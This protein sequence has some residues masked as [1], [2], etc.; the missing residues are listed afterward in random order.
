VSSISGVVQLGYQYDDVGNIMQISDTRPNR[1]QDFTYDELDRIK[2]AVSGLASITYNYDAHG[3]QQASNYTY[4]SGNPFRLQTVNGGSIGYDSNGNLT[5]ALGRTYTFGTRNL[6]DT[7]L[8]GSTTTRFVYDADDWRLKKSVDGGGPAFYYVR[9]P[10][11]QLLM[12]WQHTTTTDQMR[13]YIYLGSRLIAAVRANGRPAG[14]AADPSPP[15]T[16]RLLAGQS[17][18]SEQTLVSA[19]GRYRLRYR[20]DGNLVLNDLQ[21]GEAQLWESG[22]QFTRAGQAAMQGDGNFAI[23]NPELLACWSTGTQGNDGAYLLL[24]GDGN[25][26][27]YSAAGVA[28]WDR[29]VPTPSQYSCPI[30]PPTGSGVLTTDEQLAPGQQ[31][32]SDNGRYRLEYQNDGN[33]V[34][35]DLQTST[36]LWASDTDGTVP[37]RVLMQSDGNLVIYDAADAACWAS[38]TV[39]Y[40]GAY[41]T[42]QSDGN[43]VIYSQ[44][45][46]PVWDRSVYVPPTGSCL[47][48]PPPPASDT[49][50]PGES[51]FPGDEVRS[52]NLRYQLAYQGD[53]NLVLYDTQTSTALWSSGTNGTSPF[54]TAMQ[55]DG[56][57]VVYDI[58]GIPRWSSDTAGWYNAYLA[59]KNDGNL[60]IYSAGGV[61]IW[62]R[63]TP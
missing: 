11:G 7:A 19:N 26:V 48:A 57:L 28:L 62:Y 43:L 40:Q 47:P 25:L 5:S 14:V 46:V 55:G 52:Q 22:T 49:L 36:E 4:T 51:L 17:L 27:V 60:V 53:G 16:D 2:T 13:D 3:N 23:Y 24:Q 42:V 39:G 59:V 63:F 9:G 35:T 45:G 50:T 30:T 12:E 56:N 41:L 32:V 10:G 1:T 44:F 34:F 33:L 15:P 61:P 6:L 58:N 37:G 20:A 8:T 29:S 18:F 21:A 31:F 54:E 38:G